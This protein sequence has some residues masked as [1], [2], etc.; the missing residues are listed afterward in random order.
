MWTADH[1]NTFNTLKSILTGNLLIKPFDPNVH[2]ELVTDASRIG[3]GYALLQRDM[4]G[5]LH[6][7]QC[8]SRSLN[9]Y[10]A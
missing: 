5:E 1:K 9:N 7:I 6:L 3:L 4:Q 8:G 10:K 2:T